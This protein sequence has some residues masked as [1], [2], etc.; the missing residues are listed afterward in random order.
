MTAKSKKGF[1]TAEPGD[2]KSLTIYRTGMIM[3]IGFI[4]NDGEFFLETDNDQVMIHPEHLIDLFNFID[5]LT[6]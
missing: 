2:E 3:K 5:T 4:S 1:F 6:K